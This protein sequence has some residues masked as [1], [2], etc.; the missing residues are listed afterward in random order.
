[1]D[2]IKTPFHT[3]MT[4]AEY[5]GFRDVMRKERVQLADRDKCAHAVVP[6][7][8][9]RKKNSWMPWACHHE[10]H[11]LEQCEFKLYKR[12]ERA[13]KASAAASS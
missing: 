2:K 11:E 13:L 1:M 8:Q 10:R 9:C 5:E 3:P 7:N 6:L 4:T 12:R